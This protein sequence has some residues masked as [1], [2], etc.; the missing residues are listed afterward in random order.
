[1][2]AAK[3]TTRSALANYRDPIILITFCIMV[4]SPSSRQFLII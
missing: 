3:S 2:S 4:C 1:M